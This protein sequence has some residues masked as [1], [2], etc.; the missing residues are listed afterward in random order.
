[1]RN[2]LT[3]IS[4]LCLLISCKTDKESILETLES[5]NSSEE[6]YQIESASNIQGLLIQIQDSAMNNP[7]KYA[8]AYN[9]SV[10][11]HEKTQ[12]FTTKINEVKDVLYKFIGGNEDFSNREKPADVVLF[13][14]EKLSEN[15]IKIKQAINTYQSSTADQLYFYPKAEKIAKEFLDISDAINKDGR[16][17][18]YFTYHY[19]GMPAITSLTQLNKLQQQALTLEGV[20]LNA[21]LDNPLE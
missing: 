21:L 19:K 12:A 9:Q 15:G 5:F 2:T 7:D 8:N 10:E 14:D 1:M 17:I 11:F 18:N 13:N 16:T 6:N 3:L 20:F 4:I